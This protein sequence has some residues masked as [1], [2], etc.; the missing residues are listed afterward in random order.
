[1]TH[2]IGLDVSQKMT[3]VCVVDSSGRQLWRG[4]WPTDPEQ[5]RRVVTRHG[6][7]D[8]RVGLETGL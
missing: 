6:G 8:V 5:I 7:E 3:A 4:Q 1:M 2:Y